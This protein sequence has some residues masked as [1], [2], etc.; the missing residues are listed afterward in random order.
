VRQ[1]VV[2]VA[3]ALAAIVVAALVGI[4]AAR[5]ALGYWPDVGAAVAG[6]SSAPRF[7]NVRVV[8]AVAVIV[9]VSP[10]LIRPLRMFGRWI[11]VLGTVGAVVVGGG[12]PFGT[13]AAILI[14]LAGA[15]AINLAFGTSAGRPGIADV[16]AGLAQLGV[17]AGE[18]QAAERQVAGVFH[19]RGVDDEGRPLLVKVYGR[20]ATDTQLVSKLWRSV[21]YRGGG[22]AL[23]LGRLQS[24]EH[25]AFVTLLAAG[26]D[27]DRRVVRDFRRLAL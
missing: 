2:V 13:V 5:L 22:A 15:A 12:T 3:E 21:W 23:G 11:I 6:T 20:D 10:H 27:D 19:V 9:A 4:V 26:S 1:R 17:R 8:E 24:A 14:G 16:R 18:L 7:P 25:E